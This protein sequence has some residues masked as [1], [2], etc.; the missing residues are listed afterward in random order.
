MAQA[1]DWIKALQVLYHATVALDRA[2][3]GL[4]DADIMD[5]LPNAEE[6]TRVVVWLQEIDAWAQDSMNRRIWLPPLLQGVTLDEFERRELLK[7]TP[8]E[9]VIADALSILRESGEG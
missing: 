3:E 5:A 1:N 7:I 2:G 9:D 6:R 8:D 4:S